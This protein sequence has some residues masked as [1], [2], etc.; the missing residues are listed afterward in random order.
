[1]NGIDLSQHN[2]VTNWNEVAKNVDSVIL[3]AGYGKEF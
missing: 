3:R 2:I 1:M